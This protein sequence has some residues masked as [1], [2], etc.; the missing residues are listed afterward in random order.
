M[1]DMKKLQGKIVAESCLHR[2]ATQIIQL[3]K[4]IPQYDECIEDSKIMHPTSTQCICI[5]HPA[6]KDAAASIASKEKC[7]LNEGIKKIKVPDKTSLLCNFP[8]WR[9]SQGN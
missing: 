8:K 6:Y 3:P 9:T 4:N 5:N 1:P 2:K 7:P